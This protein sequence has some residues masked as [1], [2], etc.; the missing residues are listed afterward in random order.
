MRRRVLTLFVG[1]DDGRARAY[2][3]VAHE[4]KTW[5][6]TRWLIDRARQE[7]VPERMIRVDSLSPRPLEHEPGD[8]FDF[9]N[10]LLPIRVIE[11]LTQEAPGYE[12]RSLPS[13]PRVHLSDLYMLPVVPGLS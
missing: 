1:L 13:S 11:G 12:V 7:A 5:L 8:L 2:F 3:G 4:G 9:S 6:V 10:I